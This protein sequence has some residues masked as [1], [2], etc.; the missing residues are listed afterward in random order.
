MKN[1][2][3]KVL[4]CSFSGATAIYWFSEISYAFQKHF[5]DEETIETLVQVI[6]VSLYFP[7]TFLFLPI[8]GGV[9]ID[10]I[11]VIPI[12]Q[13][14]NMAYV[15]GAAMFIP[16]FIFKNVWLIIL[17]SLFFGFS[18]HLNF[19]ATY[20]YLSNTFITKTKSLRHFQPVLGIYFLLG[21]LLLCI[22]MLVKDYSVFKLSFGAFLM[23][24][25][26]ALCFFLKV[27]PNPEY[28]SIKNAT[29]TLPA[30]SSLLLKNEDIDGTFIEFNEKRDEDEM[31][32]DGFLYFLKDG[33]IKGFLKI[34][35][36]GIIIGIVLGVNISQIL[37]TSTE[38]LPQYISSV[39]FMSCAII[40][41]I[42]SFLKWGK[43]K[44]ENTIVMST[45]TYI[46]CLILAGLSIPQVA[47][48][49][50]F[51]VQNITIGINC[52]TIYLYFPYAMKFRVENMGKGI[53]IF[54]WI[55]SLQTF[56]GSWLNKNIISLDSLTYDTVILLPIIVALVIFV[57]LISN[58]RGT[59]MKPR[60]NS[61]PISF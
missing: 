13:F 40:G 3:W 23:L 35:T 24:V 19:T 56:L 2:Y 1:F 36:L 10:Y 60:S 45:L 52:Y 4:S 18:L 8:L 51:I 41:F 32:V 21:Y 27:K 11:G 15:I 25:S 28:G 53:G 6:T 46:G 26:T 30:L 7:N 42:L 31:N 44:L 39:R 29:A 17:A 48:I 37:S 50:V 14:L 47:K 5:D 34:A 61:M 16:G 58:D 20:V 57:V 22:P 43:T 38:P 54:W 12:L 9:M 33:G 59:N 49:G 55:I